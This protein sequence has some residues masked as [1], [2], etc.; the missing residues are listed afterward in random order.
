[1]VTFPAQIQAR[2]ED[3]ESWPL[4]ARGVA[5]LCVTQDRGALHPPPPGRGRVHVSKVA[6]KLP[7]T[8]PPLPPP[9]LQASARSACDRGHGLNELKA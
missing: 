9:R 2:T 6:L 7:S 5:Q 3:R 1:M 4:A 8:Q